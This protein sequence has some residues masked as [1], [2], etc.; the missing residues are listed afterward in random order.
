LLIQDSGAINNTDLRSPC[1]ILLAMGLPL[2]KPL[3]RVLLRTRPDQLAKIHP[4]L[5]KADTKLIEIVCAELHI[6]DITNVRRLI[7]KIWDE[8][9]Q[10]RVDII[11]D[12]D[13]PTDGEHQPKVIAYE[14]TADGPVLRITPLLNPHIRPRVNT[15]VEAWR[16]LNVSH[17]LPFPGRTDVRES[18]RGP[19]NASKVSMPRSKTING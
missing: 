17:G 12:Y 1:E 19:R 9:R 14:V 4:S 3:V 11:F 16:S 5:D 8:K 10:D 13:I 6:T 15:Q 7:I 18:R 2:I